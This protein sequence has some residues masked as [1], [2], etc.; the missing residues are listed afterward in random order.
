MFSR[1]RLGRL[2]G[3]VRTAKT[4]PH[5]FTYVKSIIL[6]APCFKFQAHFAPAYGTAQYKLPFMDMVQEFNVRNH[7]RI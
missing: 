5:E 6:R 1:Y 3:L 4:R 2:V 7:Y